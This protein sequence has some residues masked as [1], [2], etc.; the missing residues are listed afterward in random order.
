MFGEAN[1]E[2]IILEEEDQ[3][4]LK[5]LTVVMPTKDVR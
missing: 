5:Y 2:G 4:K 3:V 1:V